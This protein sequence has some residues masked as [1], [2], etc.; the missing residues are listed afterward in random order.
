MQTNFNVYV[1]Y[2]SMHNLFVPFFFFFFSF[3]LFIYGTIFFTVQNLRHVL[4]KSQ[5]TTFTFPLYMSCHA[6]MQSFLQYKIIHGF[7][8]YIKLK[9]SVCM[10]NI[11][12]KWL[13]IYI[14]CLLRFVY[15]KLGFSPLKLKSFQHRFNGFSEILII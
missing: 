1:I 9:W 6:C 4:L 12:F 8:L 15:S 13:I 5:I 2:W 7:K 10:Y 14:T 3:Y 11:I